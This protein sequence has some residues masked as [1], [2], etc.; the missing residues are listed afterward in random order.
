MKNFAVAFAIEEDN[1]ELFLITESGS[2]SIGRITKIV[3]VISEDKVKAK[4]I[5]EIDAL[6]ISIGE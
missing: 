2:V 4:L 6:K 5:L 3:D 1:Q